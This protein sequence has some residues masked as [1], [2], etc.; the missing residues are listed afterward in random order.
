MGLKIWSERC[1]QN[2]EASKLNP[3]RE[4]TFVTG[5]STGN[6]VVMSNQMNEKKIKHV[7]DIGEIAI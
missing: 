1:N 6:F 5:L 4:N 2:F 7:Y 3:E